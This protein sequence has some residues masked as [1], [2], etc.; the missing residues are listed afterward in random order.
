MAEYFSGGGTLFE[1]PLELAKD[2]IE[3]DKEFTKA[4]IVFVTDGFGFL[5]LI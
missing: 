2:K 1:P 5:T 3:L 4:D